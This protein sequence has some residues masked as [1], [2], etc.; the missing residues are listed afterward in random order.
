M[1][2][3]ATAYLNKCHSVYDMIHMAVHSFPLDN[4]VQ[5]PNCVA[6]IVE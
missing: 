4:D 3:V 2:S 1:V 5:A 6:E